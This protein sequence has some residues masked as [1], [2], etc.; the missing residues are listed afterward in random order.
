MIFFNNKLSLYKGF[1]R[2]HLPG[3]LAVLI[4]V[5]FSSAVVAV[6]TPLLGKI[7]GVVNY[8][9]QGGV[10]GMQVYVPGMPFVVITS[11]DGKFQFNGVPEGEYV[12]H[13]R[14]GE[15][16]LNQNAGIKVLAG[17]TTSLAV[18]AFCSQDVKGT[19]LEP[20]TQ[21]AT[22]PHSLQMSHCASD[23]Q[24]AK[25]KDADG[26]GVIAMLDCN[27]KNANIYPGA[28]ELCDG[29]DNNCSGQVDDNV[30]MTVLHG[31]GACSSGQVSIMSCARGFSDCDGDA[32]NGC[33]VDLMS[34]D[35]NCGSCGNACS[36]TESCGIGMC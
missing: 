35:D 26:D 22:V 32:S 29:V 4:A 14:I 33:E 12:V 20:S 23:S 9:A 21:T 31:I 36:T 15:R 24:D 28:V 2:C 34:D 19:G 1:F 30:S 16:R 27:D 10:D 11:E 17:Q 7:S 25:C 6:D 5:M 13:Y 8:C 3:S 18:I